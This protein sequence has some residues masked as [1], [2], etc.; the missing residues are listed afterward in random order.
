MYL[1][2]TAKQSE[3]AQE[4]EKHLTSKNTHFAFTLVQQQDKM[5]FSFSPRH[6]VVISGTIPNNGRLKSKRRDNDV[7]KALADATLQVAPVSVVAQ[8]Y[9]ILKFVVGIR[10]VIY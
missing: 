6:Q 8:T 5:V 3:L 2:T 10:V 4:E 7:D 1:Q 9:R